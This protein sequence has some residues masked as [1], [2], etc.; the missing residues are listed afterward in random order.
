V[1]TSDVDKGIAHATNDI[2]LITLPDGRRLAIAVFI[3]DSKADENTREKVIARIARAAYE[4][5]LQ[6]H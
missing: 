4:A 5:S 6:S 2:G 3:T 1:G